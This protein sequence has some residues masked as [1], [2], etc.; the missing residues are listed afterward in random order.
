[1]IYLLE[2][3]GNDIYKIYDAKTDTVAILKTKSL[4]DLLKIEG[5]YLMNGR[6]DKGN[7]IMNKFVN[8]KHIEGGMYKLYLG[9]VG[10]NRFAY[11]VI[12]NGKS[13]FIKNITITDRN[14]IENCIRNNGFINSR[15]INGKC[16]VQY[17]IKYNKSLIDKIQGAENIRI[18]K[19][20]ALGMFNKT[21]DN[22]KYVVLGNEVVLLNI[23]A[24]DGKIDIPKYITSIANNSVSVFNNIVNIGKNVKYI[25]RKAI[26]SFGV[27]ENCIPDSVSYI[28]RDSIYSIDNGNNKIFKGAGNKVYIAE[29]LDLEDL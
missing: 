3:N 5:N 14:D 19:L 22:I 11:R 9:K 4:L 29:N 6:V 18:N 15:Y 10:E 12:G 27:I 25:G 20:K 8:N 7:I 26:T 16:E 23:K 2:F 21:Q 17:A 13:L 28:Y 1:M 24:T